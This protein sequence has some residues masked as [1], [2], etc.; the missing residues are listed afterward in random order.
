MKLKEFQDYLKNESIGAALLIGQDINI[1]YF[2]RI[3][4]SY[5]VLLITPGRCT[6]YSSKLDSRPKVRGITVKVLSKGWENKLKSLNVRKLGINEKDMNISL[7][8][9][10]KKLFPKSRFVD[11]SSELARLREQKT[12]EEAAK[13]RK[14]CEITCKAFKALVH[15]LHKKT[16]VTEMDVSF[17]LE[18]FIRSNGCDLAFPTIVAMGKNAA[19][20]HHVT[21]T[22]RLKRGFLLIDFGAKYQNYHSDMSRVLFLGIPNKAENDAY[23]L[24][25][26]A[27][28]ETIKKIKENITAK[29]LETVARKHLGKSSSYFIHALGHGVGLEIHES[30]SFKEE[31]K[32][33]LKNS[34]FTI[35]PGIYF[36]GKFGLRIEDT[37]LFDKK[38]KILT[39]VSKRLI[40]LRD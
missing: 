35:E 16:L 29:E 34:I 36:P 33:V 17:F 8:K 19:V 5:A 21:S 27:Q 25:L 37:I 22:T 28:Q 7:F 10:L 15:E 12:R 31:E 30:P 13:V 3:K 26:R 38:I 9:K 4:L 23:N 20:P 14:A 40:C 18:K 2:T 32:A 24:L 39:T 1:T 6:L 11:I